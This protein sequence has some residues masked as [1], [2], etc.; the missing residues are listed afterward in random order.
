MPAP[1]TIVTLV[2]DDGDEFPITLPGVYRSNPN[3]DVEA[4]LKIANES[5][6]I[7]PSGQLR[8]GAIDYID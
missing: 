3:G 6:E 8:L 1:I 7:K 2:D 4:A 5:S